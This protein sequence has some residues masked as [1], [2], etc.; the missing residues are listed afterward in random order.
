VIDQ[1]KLSVSPALLDSIRQIAQ[2]ITV[3]SETFEASICQ[4]QRESLNRQNL[5][6]ALE[7]LTHALLTPP[8]VI[9]EGPTKASLSSPPKKAIPSPAFRSEQNATATATRQPKAEL[10]NALMEAGKKYRSSRLIKGDQLSN[11]DLAQIR[12]ESH[13]IPDHLREEN[14]D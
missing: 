3:H 7:N 13:S 12:T 5:A 4:S 14:W 10:L 11:E 9:P 2:E 1:P 6:T 8:P